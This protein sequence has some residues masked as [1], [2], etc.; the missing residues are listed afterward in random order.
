MQM[1][2]PRPETVEKSDWLMLEYIGCLHILYDRDIITHPI[3]K[4]SSFI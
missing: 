1:Q 4:I 2:A 3:I